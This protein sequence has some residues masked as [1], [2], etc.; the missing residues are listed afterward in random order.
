MI[1][2][3]FFSNGQIFGCYHPPGNLKLSRLLVICPPFFDEYRRLYKALA[4]LANGCASHGVH[5]LRFDY[6]GTG[7]SFG[8]LEDVSIEEWKMNIDA[9]IDEGIA[10]SG[11]DEV[12]LCGV[13]FG[14]TLASQSK[15]PQIKRYI[16]WDPILNGE[17]YLDWLS[18]VNNGLRKDHKQNA[19]L[20]NIMF[21]N[22]QYEQFHLTAKLMEGISS[23]S[24]NQM[25]LNESANSY[26]ISTDKA[27]CDSK[28]FLNCDYCGL[29]YTWPAYQDGILIQKP[30]LEAVARRVVEP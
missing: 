14:A 28:Q 11:A 3:F 6:F 26:V 12:V 21:E 2:P 8:E 17:S 20:N 16:F 24:F 22:I 30:V 9:A 5:V 13:R 7:E 15:H 18:E 10:V 19:R 25:A 4:D 27:L 1:E 29:R 23:V